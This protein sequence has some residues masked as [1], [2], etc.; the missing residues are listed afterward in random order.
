FQPQ[1]TLQPPLQSQPPEPAGQPPAASRANRRRVLNLA[2]RCRPT[3]GCQIRQNYSPEVE[4]SVNCLVNMHLR[5]SNTYLSLGFHF[6]SSDVAL[7]GLGRFFRDLARKKH[8]GAQR[9][10]TLQSQRSGSAL[11]QDVQKPS[12][13]EWGKAPDAME[14]AIVLEKNLNEAILDLHALGSAQADPYLCDFLE[15]HFLGE[16]VKVLKQMG[17]HLTNLRRLTGPYAAL[18]EYLFQRLTMK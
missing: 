11:F 1:T 10:L 5:A 15:S 7:P 6:D 17:D 9:L 14:T 4:A 3:M 13:D 18:G 12:H 2:P 8:E 16:E